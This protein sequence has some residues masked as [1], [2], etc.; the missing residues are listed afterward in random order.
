V[1]QKIEPAM[2]FLEDGHHLHLY[3]CKWTASPNRSMAS[4]LDKIKKLAEIGD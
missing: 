1:N 4:S 2:D 3:E